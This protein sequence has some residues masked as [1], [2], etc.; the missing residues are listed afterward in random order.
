MERDYI[1]LMLR[2][3]TDG[4]TRLFEG[5]SS[6]VF[7]DFPDYSNVGDTAIALGSLRFL[8]TAK[9]EV[10]SI[11][12]IATLPEWVLNS[13]TPV[14]INGGGNIAG[15]YPPCD[16]HRY[17]L[18]EGLSPKTLL[19]QGPQTVHFPAIADKEEFRQKFS[20][21]PKLRFTARDE[22]SKQ[23]CSQVGIHSDLMPDAVHML[24]A[25]DAPPPQVD[26][27]TLARTDDESS[28]SPNSP[29][30]DW[31]KDDFVTW[32]GSTVRWRSEPWPIAAAAVNP[33]RRRWSRIAHK[34]LDRGV[35]ML[36]RGETIITD[37]LHAML[38]GLQIGRSVVAV[39]NNNQKLSKYAD[40]WFG[41]ANP[42][43]RFAKSF[44][45][46]RRI[47]G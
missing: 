16:K 14:Y 39:D 45:E 25:I 46:A 43:V 29:A 20:R 28:G 22:V 26:S 40:T 24:G 17:A 27:V 31:L 32:F 36:A 12:C 3:A 11:F 5:V 30:V 41:A 13:T 18:A 9:I 21:R 38:I 35:R 37:R 8:D 4:F 42:N 10:K 23:L 47:V 1:D 34:R 33:S 19:M 2:L 44:A 7:T 6:V 15:M